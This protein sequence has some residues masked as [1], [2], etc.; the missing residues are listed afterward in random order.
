MDVLIKIFFHRQAV[1]IKFVHTCLHVVCMSIL[2]CGIVL[3]VHE[4]REGGMRVV[5]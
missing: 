3:V 2:G 5:T 4:G 1:L